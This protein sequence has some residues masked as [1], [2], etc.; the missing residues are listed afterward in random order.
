MAQL[1]PRGYTIPDGTDP[2]SAG[3]DLL[4]AN[5]TQLDGEISALSSHCYIEGGGA[6]VPNMT[7]EVRMVNYQAAY[8]QPWADLAAGTITVPAAGIYS[9]AAKVALS[10]PT[11]SPADY[12]ILIRVRSG[13]DTLISEW[14][15]NLSS[16]YGG[17]NVTAG[18]VLR[19]TAGTAVRI[20]VWYWIAAASTTT[21]TAAVLSVRLVEAL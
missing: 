8:G 15:T 12:N 20:E 18:G 5:F 2:I 16:S 1:T 7:D 3:D 14:T 19:L 4:R 21:A 10:V 11:T 6:T 17:T 9:I 13:A